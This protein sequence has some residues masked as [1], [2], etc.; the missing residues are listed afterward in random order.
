MI[1][2]VITRGYFLQNINVHGNFCSRRCWNKTLKGKHLISASTIGS[3]A[4]GR[5]EGVSK[6]PSC[7]VIGTFWLHVSVSRT[8][9]ICFSGGQSA[10]CLDLPTEPLPSIE[11]SGEERSSVVTGG[12]PISL[13][14]FEVLG[15]SSTLRDFLPRFRWCPVVSSLLL[16]LLDRGRWTRSFSSLVS[17]NCSPAQDVRTRSVKLGI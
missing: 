3:S 7:E 5:A 12:H 11:G 6:L 13:V 10:S 17:F 9:L 14:C 8:A 16:R 15:R 1:T 4:A 2:K